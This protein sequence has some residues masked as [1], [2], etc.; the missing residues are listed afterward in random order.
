MLV[1]LHIQR[2]VVPGAVRP[3]SLT[4]LPGLQ[5]P[6]EL[7]LQ[8]GGIP[9]APQFP[10]PQSTPVSPLSLMPLLLQLGGPPAQFPSTTHIFPGALSLN[11]FHSSVL[12]RVGT[13]IFTPPGAVTFLH[14]LCTVISFDVHRAMANPSF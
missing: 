3:L 5:Y 1:P 13:N 6:G 4:I 7:I 9:H 8:A 2:R 11:A 10:P 12:S 14:S